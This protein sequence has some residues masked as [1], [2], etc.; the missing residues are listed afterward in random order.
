MSK[1]AY[2][3]SFFLSHERGSEVSASRVVPELLSLIAPRSVIDIGCGLGTWTAEFQKR[4]IADVIG[5]DGDYVNRAS[6]KIAPELFLARDLTQ[7][8]SMDRRFDLAIS[9][10]VAEHLPEHRSHGFVS[11][12][13]ALAPAVLFSAAIPRQGGTNHLNEQWPDYWERLFR[14]HD[15]EALDCLRTSIW[16]DESVDWWYRQ[17]TIL[18]A[19]ARYIAEQPAL[20]SIANRQ[21]P[22]VLRLVHPTLY[23]LMHER[24]A[25]PNVRDLLY[26]LPGAVKRAIRRRLESEIP[27]SSEEFM[28]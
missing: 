1:I 4:G 28:G 8:I 15:Y 17:N 20:M 19:Q 22:A 27:D 5:I 16:D 6:L 21:P 2:Q 3:E 13:V 11:E 23:D 10:E 14:L 26:S 18:Y 25:R 24:A 7:P 12:L 9:L